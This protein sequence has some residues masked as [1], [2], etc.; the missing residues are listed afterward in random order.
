MD[1]QTAETISESFVAT[2]A[3]ILQI[4]VVIKDFRS[5]VVKGQVAVGN[6]AGSGFPK[7]N[8]R[9]F[10]FV[11][12]FRNIVNKIITVKISTTVKPL[13]FLILVFCI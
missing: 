6:N 1:F 12:P 9:K 2:E 5:K 11:F 3:C 13:L 8:I 7:S 4:V 10:R